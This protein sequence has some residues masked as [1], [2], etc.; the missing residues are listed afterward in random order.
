MKY[1]STCCAK[2]SSHA[3]TL[4]IL[5]SLRGGTWSGARAAWPQSLPGTPPLLCEARGSSLALELSPRSHTKTWGPLRPGTP[6]LGARQMGTTRFHL[7]SPNPVG[8]SAQ[9]KRSRKLQ[10]PKQRQ[11]RPMPYARPGFPRNIS[12]WIRLVTTSRINLLPN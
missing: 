10:T 12:P 6:S 11:I 3:L 4:F 5:T 7:K 2:E 8:V 1:L 9:N